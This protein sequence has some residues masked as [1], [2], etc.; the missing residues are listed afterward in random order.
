MSHFLILVSFSFF[1]NCASQCLCISFFLE[2]LFSSLGSGFFI[3]LLSLIIWSPHLTF[4]SISPRNAIPQSTRYW[5]CRCV[6]SLCLIL[7]LSSASVWL[8]H[9]EDSVASSKVLVRRL[10]CH[11]EFVTGVSNRP[12]S[13]EFH[14]QGQRVDKNFHES[15]MEHKRTRLWPR[16]SWCHLP[17]CHADRCFVTIGAGPSRSGNW[18]LSDRVAR[19]TWETP[20]LAEQCHGTLA[21]G[22]HEGVHVMENHVW[23][24]WYL[25]SWEALWRA[26]QEENGLCPLCEEWTVAV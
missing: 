6:L 12:L 20:V 1:L 22:G 4:F 5:R 2:H 19:D 13:L 16:V 10:W 8:M 23:N 3:V 15:L 18:P 26:E 14:F 21:H 11:C 25:V 9:P 7:L 17:P 24:D